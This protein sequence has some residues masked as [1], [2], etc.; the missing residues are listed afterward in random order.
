MHHA[1]LL[2]GK[3]EWALTRVPEDVCV[4]SAD[5]RHLF[6]ERMG[7][8]DARMLIEEAR[9]RPVSAPQRTFIISCDTLPHETQNALLKLFED[10]HDAVRFFLVI[11]Y[12]EML[13]PTLRSRLNMYDVE[14]AMESSDAFQEF[15]KL[16]HA[17]RLSCIQEKLKSEESV[18]VNEIIQDFVQY[19]RAQKNGALM[20]DAL[21]VS[22]Y[23]NAPGNSK[24]MILEHVAL[25]LR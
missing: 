5:V 2:I 7:I 14:S 13:L 8:S 22:T 25:S 24:K 15:C 17:D 1:E 21:M 9:L 23:V 3:R 16:P 11:P 18:W 20:H 4:Q 10:P 19:A 12:E 6:F